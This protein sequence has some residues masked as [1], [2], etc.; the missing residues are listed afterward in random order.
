MHSMPSH[1][2]NVLAMTQGLVAGLRL[3][4]AMHLLPLINP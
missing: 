2:S 3:T 1:E 4:L